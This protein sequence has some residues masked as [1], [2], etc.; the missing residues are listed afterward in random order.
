MVAKLTLT[1]LA[2]LAVGLFIWR[3]S[4]L[5]GSSIPIATTEAA[6]APDDVQI[7][8]QNGIRAVVTYLAA[9]SSQQAVFLVKIDSEEVDISHYDLSKNIVLA[10]SNIDPLPTTAIRIDTQTSRSISARVIFTKFPGNHFHFLVNNLGGIH[11]RVLH[12][13]RQI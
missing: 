13:Y 8:N 4:S 5:P 7:D 9:E 2:V 6:P 3:S 1:A 11:N 12:F 10:D